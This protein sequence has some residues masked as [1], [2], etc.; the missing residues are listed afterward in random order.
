MNSRIRIRKRTSPLEQFCSP[1]TSVFGLK[2]PLAITGMAATR[3]PLLAR[4][5]SRRWLP[6]AANPAYGCVAA[7]ARRFRPAAATLEHSGKAGPDGPASLKFEPA[8]LSASPA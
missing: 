8:G 5:P 1:A 2:H 4:Q 3:G 6:H 7:A